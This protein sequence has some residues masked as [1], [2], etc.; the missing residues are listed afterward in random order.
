MKSIKE[1]TDCNIMK[2]LYAIFD[3]KGRALLKSKT[4]RQ[5]CI[6]NIDTMKKTAETL[7]LGIENKD[8]HFIEVV[9]I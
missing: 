7:K 5:L 9:K 2:K 1:R 6:S 3:K 8:Y 4:K